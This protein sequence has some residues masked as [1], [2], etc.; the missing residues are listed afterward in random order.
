MEGAAVAG[1]ESSAAGSSERALPVPAPAAA[2]ADGAAPA[3]L[4]EQPV[5]CRHPGVA[6]RLT[7]Y[8]KKRAF[9]AVCGCLA[10]GKCVRTRTVNAYE[11]LPAQGRP[12]GFLVAWLEA[13]ESAGSRFMHDCCYP[14]AEQRRAARQR[15]RAEAEFFATL[16]TYAP[17][18]AR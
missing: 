10:H 12:L 4:P 13:A 2:G 15:W 7:F 18:R 5:R 1:A 8:P 14:T 16:E 6:G 9:E 17:A 3:A 11:K